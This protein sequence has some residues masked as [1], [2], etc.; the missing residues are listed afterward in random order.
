MSRHTFDMTLDSELQTREFRCT[1]EYSYSPEYIDRFRETPNEAASV[2]IHRVYARPLVCKSGV[3]EVVPGIEHDFTALLD[4]DALQSAIQA[5]HEDEIEAARENYFEA[6]REQL[7][8]DR[9]DAA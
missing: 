3:W 9:E 6:R 1:A 2:S 7:R 4:L 5:E 8:E